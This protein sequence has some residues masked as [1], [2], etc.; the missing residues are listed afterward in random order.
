MCKLPFHIHFSNQQEMGL[1][2]NEAAVYDVSEEARHGYSLPGYREEE[3]LKLGMPELNPQG[4]F[5]KVLHSTQ[6]KNRDS[7]LLRAWV[8][9]PAQTLCDVG[10]VTSSSTRQILHL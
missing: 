5:V 10:Q 9:N 2:L 1:Q 7:G 4:L 3:A 6:L 8:Q